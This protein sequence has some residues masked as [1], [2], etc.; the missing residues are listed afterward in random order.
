MREREEE[1]GHAFGGFEWEVDT[2][3]F[4]P[5][6]EAEDDEEPKGSWWSRMLWWWK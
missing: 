5:E 1:G 3:W 2:D 4:E 6:P